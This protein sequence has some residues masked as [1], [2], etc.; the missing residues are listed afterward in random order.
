MPVQN[1]APFTL[2]SNYTQKKSFLDMVSEERTS[3]KN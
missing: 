3:D 2:N 1:K